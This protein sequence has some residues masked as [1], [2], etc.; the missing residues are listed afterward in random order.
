[1]NKLS[2]V[3]DAS[4][5][6]IRVLLFLTSL[7]PTQGGIAS[8]N[9]NVVRA[10]F[11]M[12][13]EVATGVLAYHGA[14]PELPADYLNKRQFSFAVGCE[15]SK[16]RLVSQYIRLSLS[17]R[18]A[19]I[20]VDHLHLAVIPYLFRWIVRVPFVVTCHG[21]E[22]DHAVTKLRRVAFLR[23]R[24]RLTNSNFTADRLRRM[25]PG[26]QIDACELA[27]D[28]L[29]IPEDAAENVDSLIDAFGLSQPLG[30]RFVLIVSRLASKERYK[31]HD[32]L[33]A[34]MPS[35]IDK[36]PDA[37]LVI[38]GAGDDAERLQALARESGAGKAVLFTGF[39]PPELLAALY[40]R[41]RLFAMP[42]R[43]EGFGLVYLE[44]MRF[45]KPCV[46]STVDAGREVVADGETGLLVDPDNLEEL[47]AA[48][49]R[50]L[51]DDAL[52]ARLGKTGLARLE[53]RYR[54]RHYRARLQEKLAEVVPAF[55]ER[56]PSERKDNIL[57]SAGR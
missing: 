43:G 47:R 12:G 22:F 26:V 6:P 3:S 32:Q 4:A 27:L 13:P 30:Q 20:F 46:A 39:A 49:E 8:A 38:V 15:S 29:G 31:G 37:Q 42:S 50:L 33:I 28:D 11:E 14:T 2:A 48:V 56:C 53:G 9:R 1:M 52:A 24:S 41:C 25:F 55:A 44:A 16:L 21:I 10:L 23:A 19:L 5:P 57:V 36:I 54:F 17:W 35:I 7:H 18:P 40:A 34:I 45:A 51:R